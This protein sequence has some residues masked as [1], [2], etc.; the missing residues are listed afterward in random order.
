MNVNNESAMQTPP[1]ELLGGTMQEST[2]IYDRPQ[3]ACP[4]LEAPLPASSMQIPN[5]RRMLGESNFF[6]VLISLLKVRLTIL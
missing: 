5:M 3:R 1:F 6:M 4:V 2:E